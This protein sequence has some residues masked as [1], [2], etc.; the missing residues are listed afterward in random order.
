[1][2]TMTSFNFN[3]Q[4]PADPLS[5]FGPSG[6]SGNEGPL[7]GQIVVDGQY[8]ARKA[9]IKQQSNA[10]N[11]IFPSR[12][13]N[14]LDIVQGDIV[15]VDK[16]KK[17]DDMS[18]TGVA[19]VL[20]SLNNEGQEAMLLF[21]SDFTMQREAMLN[22]KIP[23]GVARS[24][25]QYTNRMPSQNQGLSVQH[26]GKNFLFSTVEMNVGQFAYV[27]IA[28]PMTVRNNK[29]TVSPF[30]PRDKVTLTL[31]P[32]NPETFS[33]RIHTHM[34]HYLS[35]QTK[36]EK[37]MNRDYATTDSWSNFCE[38]M[39][40]HELMSFLIILDR[41]LKNDIIRVNFNTTKKTMFDIR[42]D[43]NPALPIQNKDMI[44]GLAKAFGILKDGSENDLTGVRVQEEHKQFYAELAHECM[45]SIHCAEDYAQ[46][47]YGWDSGSQRN[48]AIDSRNKSIRTNTSVGKMLMEQFMNSRRLYLA[49]ADAVQRDNDRKFGV[50]GSP[51]KSGGTVQI[52]L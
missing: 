30:V 48:E 19:M 1:M 18:S 24:T 16:K 35:D 45:L 25:I 33:N 17:N 27:T 14:A 36:W 42:T 31:A 9:M 20:S 11:S 7:E 32:Y 40:R 51:S 6:G 50:V 37:A 47:A 29:R 4:A 2:A 44:L 46:L 12:D 22:E 43:P 10:S 49:F 3:R 21:P 23:I 26:R 34:K 15:Y 28:D 8:N 38:T 5:G 13:V 41:M 52:I 39:K